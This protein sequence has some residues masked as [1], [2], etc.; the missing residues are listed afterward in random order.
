MTNE[1]AK[2]VAEVLYTADGGCRNCAGMLVKNMQTT[3]PEFIWKDLL[4]DEEKK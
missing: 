2:K 1:E 4:T 3:F